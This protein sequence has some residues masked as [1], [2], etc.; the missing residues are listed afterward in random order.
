MGR[1]A[2]FWVRQGSD[3]TP[4]GHFAAGGRR[5]Q[6]TAPAS[7]GQTTHASSRRTPVYLDNVCNTLVPWVPTGFMRTREPTVA[8]A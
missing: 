6:P 3:L 4:P 1:I 5:R 7:N 2:V 8:P